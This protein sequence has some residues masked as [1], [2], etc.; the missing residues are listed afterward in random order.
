MEMETMSP[1]D[2]DVQ[3]A[4][5]PEL[6]IQALAQAQHEATR[7]NLPQVLMRDGFLL[8]IQGESVTI[9]KRLAGRKQVPSSP[10]PPHS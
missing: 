6:A 10:T 8:R 1:N 5:V 3:D 7:A 4:D 2:D 9:L